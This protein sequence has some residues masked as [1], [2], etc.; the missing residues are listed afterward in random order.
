MGIAVHVRAEITEMN[1]LAVAGIPP[2][3]SM[4]GQNKLTEA[5]DE[6]G[7]VRGDLVEF[8]VVFLSEACL[9]QNMM[10]R[11]VAED[12]EQRRVVVEVLC[13]NGDGRITFV[14]EKFSCRFERADPDG[15]DEKGDVEPRRPSPRV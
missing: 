4:T 6:H 14:D 5:T 7:N 10:A 2:H 15:R 3:D 12:H 1:L 9:E 13:R 8:Q 11:L